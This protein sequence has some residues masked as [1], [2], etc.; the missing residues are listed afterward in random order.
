MFRFAT[1]KPWKADMTSCASKVAALALG[2]VLLM[3]GAARATTI[4]YI[5]TGTGT[6]TLGGSA[7][8]GGFGVTL[9]GDT[10][11]VASASPF[12][13]DDVSGTFVAGALSATLDSGAQMR[14]INGPSGSAVAG[15]GQIQPGPVFFVEEAVFTDALLGYDLKTAFPLTSGIVSA[16][17]Q[18]FLTNN[19]DLT[20]NSISSLSFEADLAAT[21]LPASWVMML[22]LLA[23]AWFVAQWHKRNRLGGLAAA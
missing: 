2:V 16:I 19:G 13:S 17:V 23:F 3:G 12:F 20:F 8:S 7:F 9:V 15:F 10:G 21:P 4:D 18:T 5:F 1:L 22:T 6:G 11:T 14:L